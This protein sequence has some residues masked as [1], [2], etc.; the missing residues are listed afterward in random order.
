VT[1]KAAL[2]DTSPIVQR[3][4]EVIGQLQFPVCEQTTTNAASSDV[5]VA[6]A[7]FPHL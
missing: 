4:S 1:L 6:C 2:P 3:H 5:R 7:T